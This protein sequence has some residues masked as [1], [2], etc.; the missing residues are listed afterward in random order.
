MPSFSLRRAIAILATWTMRAAAATIGRVRLARAIQ[1]KRGMPF[2]DRIIIGG[3]DNNR[4]YGLSV[5][6]V[7]KESGSTT[8]LQPATA[9]VNVYTTAGRIVCEGEF[10]IYDML[11]RDVT[12]LNGSLQG[13][14]VVKTDNAAVKVVV[15]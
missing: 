3:I 4:Y 15:R 2:S 13:V 10:R 6:A 12:R 1:A 14:Y 5:R 7:V 9:A 11:G 8:A